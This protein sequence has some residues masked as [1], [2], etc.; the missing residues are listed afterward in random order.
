MGIEPLR[1]C[2]CRPTSLEPTCAT[3]TWSWCVPRLRQ[4]RAG[5]PCALPMGV[6]GSNPTSSADALACLQVEL[7]GADLSNGES[8]CLSVS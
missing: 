7:E 4:C 3:P 1:R 6:A 8:P 5:M 2:Y